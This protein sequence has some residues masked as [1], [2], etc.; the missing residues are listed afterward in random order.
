M[1]SSDFLFQLIKSLS[2]G[3]RRNFKL[4]SKLQEGDKNYALLFEAMDRQDD[5]DERIILKEFQGEKFTRQL[6]VAKNYLYNF[7]LRTLHIFDKGPSAELRTL[8][9]QVELLLDKNLFA[10]AEKILRKATHMAEKQESFEELLQALRYRRRILIQ[11]SRMNEFTVF[12]QEIQEEEM[13]VLEKIANLQAYQHLGDKI[14]VEKEK[15]EEAR[16]EN[17]LDK[18]KEVLKSPLMQDEKAPLSIRAQILRLLIM[19]DCFRFITDIP[20]CL[21]SVQKAIHIFQTEPF[22]REELNLKYIHSLTNCAVY[23]FILGDYDKGAELLEVLNNVEAENP[24]EKLAIFERYYSLKIANCMDSGNIEEGKRVLAGFERQYPEMEGHMRKALQ[25]A[26]FQRIANFWLIAGEPR[27]AL[28]WI[29]KILNEPKT[30]TRADIQCSSRILN[31][32]IHYELGNKELVEYNC[33]SAYRFIYKRKRLF[34]FERVSLK[35]LRKLATTF[36]YESEQELFVEFK[37]ELTEAL[38][39][40]FE[41]NGL[42]LFDIDLWLESKIKGIPMY[43]IRNEEFIEKVTK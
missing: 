42:S 14:Y 12:F 11:S 27:E 1:R 24:Q 6:S 28:V 4:F 31:L 23:H 34:G 17:E 29:N 37:N 5:Y 43:R 26:L 32:V 22:I 9:H 8:L 3:E 18:F 33:K 19:E 10:H 40:P 13:A 21:D 38:K 30:E 41:E 2:K 15:A 16:G 20:G 7:I 35:Y 36:N 25:F 39:N